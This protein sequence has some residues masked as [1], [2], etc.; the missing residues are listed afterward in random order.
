VIAITRY[1]KRPGHLFGGFG[2][3]SGMSGFGILAAL[4]IQKLA[5]GVPIGNRPLFF[6]GILLLLLGV[7]LI[8]TGVLGEI[9]Y[10]HAER[11]RHSFRSR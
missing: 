11:K 8:S 7:Q 5:F 9:I 2:L 6:L 3:L 10:Y 1:L 4:S